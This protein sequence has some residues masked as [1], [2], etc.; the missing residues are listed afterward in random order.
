MINK[1][2][3][4]FAGLMKAAFFR[5]LIINIDR[6]TETLPSNEYVSDKL[7]ELMESLEQDGYLISMDGDTVRF[8]DTCGDAPVTEDLHLEVEGRV[9]E[10]A[11]EA[12]K[13]RKLP[14]PIQRSL[15]DGE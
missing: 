2:D 4:P 9:Y 11:I 14:G 3:L 5:D 13:A 10:A 6:L 1:S 7:G 8:Q 15:M 12:Q